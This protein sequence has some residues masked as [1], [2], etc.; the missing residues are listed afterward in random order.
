MD[1]M[2]DTVVYIPSVQAE[3]NHPAEIIINDKLNRGDLVIYNDIAFAT[4]SYSLARLTA[5]L[6]GVAEGI[7]FGKV[8]AVSISDLANIVAYPNDEYPEKICRRY[9]PGKAPSLLWT[10]DRIVDGLDVRSCQVDLDI[11][12]MSRIHWARDDA[13]RLA[14]LRH[15]AISI[16]DDRELVPPSTVDTLINNLSP[17]S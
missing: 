14:Q 9:P 11:E 15:S 12:K 17:R 16:S 5:V 3:R 6:M 7:S 2:F 8:T 4:P 13:L 1:D 10:V